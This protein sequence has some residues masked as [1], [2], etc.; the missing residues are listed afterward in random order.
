MRVFFLVLLCAIL[1]SVGLPVTAAVWTG[2][3]LSDLWS[4]AGNGGGT[5]LPVGD[6]LIFD[7]TQRLT[8]NN[9]TTAANPYAGI[10]FNPGAGAFTISG[11][12][13]TLAGDIAST[14]ANP[15]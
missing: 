15:Q 5:P 3:G 14:S 7:G 4:D 10:T 8:P 12:S 1:A 2:G 11:N 9:D 13:I 6:P